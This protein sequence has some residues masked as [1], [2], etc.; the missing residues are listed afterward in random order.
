[1]SARFE[2]KFYVK[3][4]SDENFKES[5]ANTLTAQQHILKQAVVV[6]RH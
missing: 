6:L 2:T 3:A 5:L 4:I 1:M